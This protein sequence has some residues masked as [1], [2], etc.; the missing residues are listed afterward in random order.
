MKTECEISCSLTCIFLLHCH[1][2]PQVGIFK[3]TFIEPAKFMTP[4]NCFIFLY[5]F[6]FCIVFIYICKLA[7]IPL[8][9]KGVVGFFPF[10]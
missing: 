2:L 6:V 1:I 9:E 3:Q 10:N 5:I 4:H 7:R 8:M